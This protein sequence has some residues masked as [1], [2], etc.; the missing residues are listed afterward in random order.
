MTGKSGMP[1]LCRF[2]DCDRSETLRTFV[3]EKTGSGM[4]P[5]PVWVG[6]APG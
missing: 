2:G 1:V 3:Q 6:V 4:M 5:G